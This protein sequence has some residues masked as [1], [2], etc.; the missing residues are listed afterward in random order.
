MAK[1]ARM[2]VDALLD[3]GVKSIVIDCFADLDTSAAA[4]DYA[5][6]KSLALPNIKTLV[7][8]LKAQYGL[9]YLIYGSGI[10]Q[11]SDSLAFLEGQF[12]VLGNSTFSIR[13]LQN[14]R[15]FFQRLNSSGIAFPEVVF[16]QPEKL[17]GWLV[18]SFKSEGGLGVADAIDGA[19]DGA[20]VYW[21]RYMPGQV[22]SALFAAHA[23]QN[24]ATILGI[25]KQLTTQG[26]LFSGV[27]TELEFPNSVQRQLLEWIQKIVDC[28]ALTGINGLDFIYFNQRCYVLEINPRPTA[29][30]QLYSKVM[31]THMQSY[32]G[33]DSQNRT[34][35]KQYRGFKI[36]YAGTFV[37]IGS[38]IAWPDW[39]KDR[40]QSGQKIGLGLPV[41]SIV[42]TAKSTEQLM[43]SLDDKTRAIENF[44]KGNLNYAI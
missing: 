41:C 17:T 29:S 42:A 44:L 11:Y 43:K 15:Y 18:K 40:P 25:Q 26:Y 39:V 7:Q 38:E 3:I 28:F 5:C 31:N 35:P 23:A 20:S 1:S 24:T 13:Q 12:V 4:L 32:F 37:E 30:I 10:E 9:N 36:I 8:Q 14:K 6:V 34:S 16:Q 19:Q 33:D 2:L 21:Q 22:M 27:I